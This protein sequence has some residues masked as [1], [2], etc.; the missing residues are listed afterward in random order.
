MQALIVDGCGPTP[1]GRA[2]FSRFKQQVEQAFSSFAALDVRPVHFHVR[3]STNLAEFVYDDSPLPKGE[4]P[5]VG[6]KFRDPMAVTKFDRLDFIF[7]DMPVDTAPWAPQARQVLLLLK[8]VLDTS[9]CAFLGGAAARMLAFVQATGATNLRVL[10]IGPGPATDGSLRSIATVPV[11]HGAGGRPAFSQRDVCIDTASG[12]VYEFDQENLCWR[13]SFGAGLRQRSAGAAGCERTRGVGANGNLRRAPAHK[14][15]AGVLKHGRLGELVCRVRVEALQHWLFEGMRASKPRLEFLVHTSHVWALDEEAGSSATTPYTSLADGDFGPLIGEVGNTI[16]ANFEVAAAGDAYPEVSRLLR[17]YV[18]VKFRLTLEYEHL[19]SSSSGMLRPSLRPKEARRART[20]RSGAGCRILSAA[21]L[22]DVA[23]CGAEKGSRLPQR[24][25]PHSTQPVPACGSRFRPASAPVA[26]ALGKSA[27]LAASGNSVRHSGC[28]SSGA[29]TSST[30]TADLLRTPLS[31]R[32][33][34]SATPRGDLQTNARRPSHSGCSVVR[35]AEA[36]LSQRLGSARSSRAPSASGREIEEDTHSGA[37]TMSGTPSTARSSFATDSNTG[38]VGSEDSC[39]TSCT[40]P[41]LSV[42]DDEDGGILGRAA[43][44]RRPAPRRVRRLNGRSASFCNHSVRICARADVPVRANLAS[45]T[46]VCSRACITRPS[47]LQKFKAMR[48]H[49]QSQP[50]SGW[51]SIV[52]DGPYRSAQEQELHDYH[53]G[54]K[55]WMDKHAFQ[56]AVGKRTTHLKVATPINTGAGPWLEPMQ[57]P[58]AFRV[59]DKRKNMST[60]AFDTHGKPLTY[61]KHFLAD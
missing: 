46:F 48:R 33:A 27:A 5:K 38:S 59:E 47:H 49:D 17:R 26:R 34:F 19:D 16:F 6:G 57:G 39:A 54:K 28:S 10:N 60:R 29:S 56:T 52:N 12:D 53:A 50:A 32:S 24:A 11:R 9:K 13:P 58:L 1:S 55:K 22:A 41:S 37:G 3:K 44:R 25:S 23:R 42:S 18:E 40:T 15:V 21:A 8:M 43:A 35:A 14:E 31:A 51:Y 30:A 61:P 20:T 7:V 36:E 2:A 45:H 4:R